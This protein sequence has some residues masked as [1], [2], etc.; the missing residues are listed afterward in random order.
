MSGE[1]R[2]PAIADTLT[3]RLLV[4]ANRLGQPFAQQFGHRLGI[5]LT[6]W[7]C[8]MALAVEPGASGEAV[9]R[10][11]GLE[12]MT[13]S[14]AL[15]RLDRLAYAEPSGPGNRRAWR[16]TASGWRIVDEIMPVALERDRAALAGVGEAERAAVAT[17]LERIAA[18]PDRT[19][20]D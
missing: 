12:K 3:F 14:R 4:A 10:R 6:Q 7:R 15:R 1:R 19:D 16:L 20:A 11:M 18:A 13:V 17:V 2:E 8:I 5:T 9:A